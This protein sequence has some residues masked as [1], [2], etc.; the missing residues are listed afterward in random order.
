MLYSKGGL[1]L[2]YGSKKLG[3]LNTL[4]LQSKSHGAVIQISKHVHYIDMY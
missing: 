1:I 3:F 2:C 4:K